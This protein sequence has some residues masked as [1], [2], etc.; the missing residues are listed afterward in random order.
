M[1]RNSRWLATMLLALGCWSVETSASLADWTAY[2]VD[3]RG[4]FGHGRAATQA[5]ASDYALGYCGSAR[6]FVVMTSEARCVA[7]ATSNHNGYWVG[8]GASDTSQQASRLARRFC[9]ENAPRSS[10]NINHTYC[11]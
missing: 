4:K 8:T 11:Q 2:A 9:S 5:Q 3:G 7:L 10:C 6:C 1:Q